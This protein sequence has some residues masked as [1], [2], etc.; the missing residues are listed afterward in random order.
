MPYVENPSQP[1]SSEVSIICNLGYALNVA[2][3]TVPVGDQQYLIGKTV[4]ESL[5]DLVVESMQ[6]GQLA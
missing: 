4:S 5:K 6:V 1:L 2:R 3:S